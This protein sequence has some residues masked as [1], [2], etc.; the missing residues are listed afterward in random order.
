VARFLH[1]LV[2]YTDLVA[3]MVTYVAALWE[4]RGLK[5]RQAPE[6]NQIIFSALTLRPCRLPAL[7]KRML[8]RASQ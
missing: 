7:R 2:A 5:G 3:A 4:N 8:L 1:F 6:V